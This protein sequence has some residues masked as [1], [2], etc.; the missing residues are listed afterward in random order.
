[1]QDVQVILEQALTER[2]ILVS[3]TQLEHLPA[4][5]AQSLGHNH[6]RIKK[7]AIAHNAI[8]KQAEII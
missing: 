3:R 6:L 4:M 1:M 7:V 8:T 5:A 2:L